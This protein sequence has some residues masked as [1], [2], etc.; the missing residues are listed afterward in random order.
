MSGASTEY[1]TMRASKVLGAFNKTSS[2]RYGI[3][4]NKTDVLK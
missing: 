1:P 2:D 3:S 4:L